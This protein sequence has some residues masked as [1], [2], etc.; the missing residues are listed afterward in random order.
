VAGAGV[1]ADGVGNSHT[2]AIVLA[3]NGP[4]GS[5]H[6]YQPGAGRAYRGD[7]QGR[8][9]GDAI[10]AGRLDTSSTVSVGGAV[11]TGIQHH[12]LEYGMY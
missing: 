2:T 1:A 9:K 3:E 11:G 5:M 12:Y 10:A 7:D 6:R 8:R 4:F